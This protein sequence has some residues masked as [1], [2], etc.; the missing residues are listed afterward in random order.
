MMIFQKIFL[1]N[2]S[3][4]EMERMHLCS[5]NINGHIKCSYACVDTLLCSGL[6]EMVYIDVLQAII[7]FNM[8]INY[9][10]LTEGST[11]H[12]CYM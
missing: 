9:Y 3:I 8:F 6:T 7:A 1:K 5:G 2:N 12:V 10:S 4:F 11:I